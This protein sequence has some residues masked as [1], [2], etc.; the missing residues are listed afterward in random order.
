MRRGQKV[1][2]R[3]RGTLTIYRV[4]IERSDGSNTIITMGKGPF[5]LKLRDGLRK[6]AASREDLLSHAQAKF[7]QQGIAHDSAPD[8]AP[9][10]DPFPPVEPAIH[11]PPYAQHAAEPVIT[12]SGWGDEFGFRPDFQH[13]AASDT[14]GWEMM[15][16]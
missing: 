7:I 12:E 10:L 11:H 2:L 3:D 5:G 8:P 16:L 6:L 15:G 1:H 4:A 9:S 13:E 14:P